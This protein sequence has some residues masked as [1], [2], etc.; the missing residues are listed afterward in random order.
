VKS[1]PIPNPV[2]F[3]E[4]FADKWN[5]NPELPK[6]FFNWLIVRKISFVIMYC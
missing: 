2:S 1:D 5:E 4:N 6:A 3:D